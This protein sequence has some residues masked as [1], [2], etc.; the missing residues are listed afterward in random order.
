M[1][2]CVHGIILCC[3]LLFY[4]IK[5]SAEYEKLLLAEALLYQVIE[6]PGQNQGV[7]PKLINNNQDV[8]HT[9][10]INRH[11]QVWEF[12]TKFLKN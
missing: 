10:D 3:V 4:I 11:I 6:T 9:R 5:V 2:S 12:Q 8:R 1:G 7:D